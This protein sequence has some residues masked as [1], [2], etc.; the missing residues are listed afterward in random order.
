[1]PSTP[2]VPRHGGKPARGPPPGARQRRCL[3]QRQVRGHEFGLRGLGNG[4]TK[5]EYVHPRYLSSL[6]AIWGR[7][8][9]VISPWGSDSEAFHSAEKK[10]YFQVVS[11]EFIRWPPQVMLRSQV[12]ILVS[13]GSCEDRFTTETLNAGKKANANSSL[14]E[15]SSQTHN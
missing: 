4:Q 8:S 1:M 15:R 7:C 6:D 14:T 13:L 11:S 9:L 10:A 5:Q 2:R 3:K 12:D